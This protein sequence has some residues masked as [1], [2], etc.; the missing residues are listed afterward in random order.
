MKVLRTALIVTLLAVTSAQ[1]KPS[2][3]SSLNSLYGFGSVATSTKSYISSSKKNYNRHATNKS[4]GSRPGKWCGWYM[5]T[6]F[7]GGPE[8][9][10]ARNWSKRGTP[11][12]PQ[13]GA[14]VVWPHHVGLITGRSSNGRWIVKS[15]NDSNAVRER[16]RSVAG[17]IAFRVL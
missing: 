3:D 14:V 10:L 13:V 7:G 2:E 12:G 15:G 11:T 4:V 16:P 5:R 17:A 1:A 8:Y 9:N 6:L